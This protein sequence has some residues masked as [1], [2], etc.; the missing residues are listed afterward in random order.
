MR[1][2]PTSSFLKFTFG[3]ITFLVVSFGL[4]LAVSKLNSTQTA[5][6]Q[7]AAAQALILQ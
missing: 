2:S 3:F 5:A 1:K 6:Q 4:T 7:A